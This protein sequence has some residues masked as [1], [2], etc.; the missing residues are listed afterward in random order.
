M[1][2]GAKTVLA[3][4]RTV[5][6]IAAA[7]TV[8]RVRV[9]AFISI[10]AAI[11]ILAL[12][13]LGGDAPFDAFGHPFAVDLT[14]HL[15][16]G[17]IARDGDLGH[18]Y[19]VGR[20]LAA[21]RDLLGGRHP[22]FLDL[23]VSPPFTAFIYLPLANR[24]YLIAAAAW[25]ALTVSL[26]LASLWLL[27]PL[28]PRL[29]RF[30]FGLVAVVVFSA[31]PTIEVIAAGQDSAFALLLLALGLRLLVDRRDLL[32]GAVLG[33]G[34]FKPT[35]FLLIPLVL[36][37][38]RRPRALVTCLSVGST[39]GVI[40][41][42]LVGL[43]GLQADASLLSSEFWHHANALNWW[44]MQ[45]V[46]ALV[47][48]GV[49]GLPTAALTAIAVIC[50]H[51]LLLNGPFAIAPARRDPRFGFGLAILI[52]ALVSPHFFIYDCVVLL[53]PA[54]LLVDANPNSSSIRVVLLAGWIATWSAAL[55]FL[56]FGALPFPFWLLA[57]PP[58]PLIIALLAWE[59]RRH[60]AGSAAE[61]NDARPALAGLRSSFSPDLNRM[62]SAASI[63][64]EFQKV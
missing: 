52:T 58:L 48:I 43:T 35:L 36:L 30:G 47:Q 13:Y 9:D 22:E 34:V 8:R 7:L 37:L 59:T 55:R 53:I 41:I 19:D 45:S 4:S 25:T 12:T 40:S 64:R 60:V 39:L 11:A 17:R 2:I 32:A 28:L 24:P 33:V 57:S 23:F 56:V 3:P 26:L 6:R 16:G 14:A 46:P 38:E 18:L 27:W 5:D 44:K 21:E 10:L 42:G 31:W 29:H 62:S 20:Q 50:G 51:L 61:A 63:E 15:A 49:D 1:T 54:L